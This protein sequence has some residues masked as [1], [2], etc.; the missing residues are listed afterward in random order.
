MNIIWKTNCQMQS[1]SKF[2]ISTASPK[3]VRLKQ[4]MYNVMYSDIVYKTVLFLQVP[5]QLGDLTIVAVF[6]RISNVV[7][8]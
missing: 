7:N 8:L 6:K 2:D 1:I 5:C 4:L 3:Q